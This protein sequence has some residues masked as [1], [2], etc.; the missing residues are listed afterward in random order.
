MNT[1]SF[2]A[3]SRPIAGDLFRAALWLL[4]QCIRLPVFLFLLTLEPVANLFLG[5]LAL[6]GVLTALFWKLFGPPGFHVF[7]VIT[8]ALG[9][10]F[11]L[12]VYHFLLRLLSR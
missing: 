9:L 12:L 4:W 6:L 11:A 1:R 5:T 10:Q 7:V 3:L 8:I 2:D